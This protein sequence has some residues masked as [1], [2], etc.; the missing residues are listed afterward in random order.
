M[1]VIGRDYIQQYAA[2]QDYG[3]VQVFRDQELMRVETLFNELGGKPTMDRVHVIFYD[4]LL[5]HPWLRG[6]FVG[7]RKFHLEG[8][9]TDFMTGLLGGPKIYGGRAPKSAHVHLFVTEEVFMLRH[10][11]LEDSLMEAEI[12][13]DLK[14]RWLRYDMKMKRALVKES[15]SECEG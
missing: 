2:Q 13:A 9:Q 12:P 1:R 11:I 15:V 5:A 3:A 10:K 14:E 8:Q 7:V 4:K 6:F